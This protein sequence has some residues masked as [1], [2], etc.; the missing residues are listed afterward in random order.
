MRRLLDW[1]LAW[2]TSASALT[3]NRRKLSYL[4]EKVSRLKR[5]AVE[6]EQRM[7]E[8]EARINRLQREMAAEMDRAKSALNDAHRL[9]QKQAEALDAAQE[10]LRTARDITIPGLVSSHQ[11]LIGRMEAEI[12]M[13][14]A[15]TAMATP[16]RGA[17]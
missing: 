1:F 3:A 14:A 17:E 13:Q 4:D 15:R 10:E 7:D 2:R 5:E 11:V 12:A 8:C 9:S 16:A 6:A